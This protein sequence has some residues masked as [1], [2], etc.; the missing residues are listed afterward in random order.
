MASAYR[1]IQKSFQEAYKERSEELRKRLVEWR[2]DPAVVRVE[3]P[4][5]IARV[6]SLGYRAKQGFVVARVRIRRSSGKH[7]RPVKARKPS[8]MGVLK[9]KRGKSI[10][11]MA[12]E[13]AARKFP[14]LEVLNSYYVA[15]DGQYY[16][17]EVIMVDPNHP[18]IKNDPKINWVT[19]VKG[20][21][22]RGLTSAGKKARGLLNKGKGAEKVRPSLRANQRK[23][24]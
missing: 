16:W 13:R 18:A 12:E 24:K 7:E 14:N 21:V 19:R 6:R 10:Q 22:F 3:K 11:W 15:E 23:G 4:T 17:Y 1:Y 9:K 8:K 2:R 20:R 5:N